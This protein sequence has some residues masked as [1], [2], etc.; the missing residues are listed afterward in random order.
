M[1][2]FS[3]SPSLAIRHLSTFLSKPTAAKLDKV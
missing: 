2:F 1:G 3:S